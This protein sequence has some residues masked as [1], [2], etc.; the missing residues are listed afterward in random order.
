M[1]KPIS[2]ITLNG[3]QNQAAETALYPKEH[4]LTYTILGLN[5][6]AGELADK[7][8]KVIRD[9]QGEMSEET[10]QAMAKELGDVLWYVAMCAKELGHDLESIAQ[11]N[12]TKLFSRKDRGQI[13]GAG[14]DR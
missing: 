10:Q 1:S 3:Y 13:Q 5:G 8:K 9:H 7:Y 4:G 11:M 12:L 6:E 2:S 14:D